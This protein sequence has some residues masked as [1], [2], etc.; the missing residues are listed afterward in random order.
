MSHE[1]SAQ[2]E[3]ETTMLLQKEP[4]GAE[5]T[6]SFLKDI[7]TQITTLL[8]NYRV[9]HQVPFEAIDPEIAK[10]SRQVVQE[11]VSNLGTSERERVAK[12]L[13][14]STEFQTIQ[15]YITN[16][17]GLK[18]KRFVFLQMSSTTETRLHSF[19]TKFKALI[20]FIVSFFPAVELFI[21]FS[22][23]WAFYNAW[24]L[25]SNSR[26][27][28]SLLH[29]F[30]GLFYVNLS[31]ISA[32]YVYFVITSF[33]IMPISKPRG[34]FILSRLIFPIYFKIVKSVQVLKYHFT[35][36]ASYINH[37]EQDL[38]EKEYKKVLCSFLIPKACLENLPQLLI[39]VLFYFSIPLQNNV[40]ESFDFQNLA[41]LSF[42]KSVVS[43]GLVARVLASF[44]NILKQRSLGITAL[45]VIILSNLF[46]LLSR[47]SAI[48]FCIIF[49]TACPD[50][51]W[52]LYH[53]S[54]YRTYSARHAITPLVI[55]ALYNATISFV[56]AIL[57]VVVT[58]LAFLLQGTVFY[59]MT[60]PKL[61][62][63]LNLMELWTS[64][65]INSFCPFI[66]SISFTDV[67]YKAN[68]TR[69]NVASYSIHFIVN[70]LLS[71]F[72][73]FFYGLHFF[74]TTL[75]ILDEF[76][77]FIAFVRSSE[78]PSSFPNH[79]PTHLLFGHLIFPIVTFSS[80]TL[81][82][83][84]QIIYMRFFHPNKSIP[85]DVIEMITKE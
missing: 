61:K 73:I 39:A 30:K 77:S 46:F 76:C 24:T 34:A 31:L 67:E 59:C 17:V 15:S 80:F 47:A 12:E 74:Q 4:S 16:S 82:L 68:Q 19:Q 40:T 8:Y 20:E 62:T 11:I 55:E 44:Q 25:Y 13:R 63:N 75:P 3:K 43:I 49:S 18:A 58:L 33:V 10:I 79:L 56:P 69:I 72:P 48:L 66:P 1:F 41:F 9:D 2:E 27:G 51:Q 42:L 32:S 5:E 52:F 36:K 21:E 22:L 85:A 71:T 35:Q 83:L 54:S 7:D 84:F 60:N 50:L 57:V 29:H 81:G 38:V 14:K 28:F 6:P 37:Q 26:S 45:L 78:F 70:T 23:V 65:I 53:I 64:A